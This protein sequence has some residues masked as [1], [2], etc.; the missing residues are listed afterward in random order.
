MG[1]RYRKTSR[2]APEQIESRVLLSAITDLI[3]VNHI[4][5]QRAAVQNLFLQGGSSNVSSPIQNQ[6]ESA[7]AVPSSITV[8]GQTFTQVK[9][10]AT[11]SN[12]GPQG[13]NVALTPTGFLT[14]QELKNETFNAVFKGPYTVGPGPTSD[15][16]ADYYIRGAGQ[17]TT[18]LHGDIQLR[19]VVPKDPGTPFGAVSA[20]FDRNLN[21]NTV[22]GFD[23]ST[24]QL[25][26]NGQQI[27]V[28]AAGRPNFLSP[29]TVDVNS[30]SG[31]YDEAFSQGTI[32]ITYMP[33]RT[34][35]RGL[36][37]Q[38]TAIIRIHALIYT[39]NVDFILANSD[40]DP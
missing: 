19:I 7:T 18:F 11:S 38:G 15:E 6:S 1:K 10:I 29:I 33:S 34:R 25:D 22:L 5:S 30:S 24:P 4:Q 31:L 13:T 32:S 40:I 12:Q 8:G 37:G 26:A 9:S 21:S 3:I 35:T 27:N 36:I 20:I 17:G 28:D 39:P 2:L 23:S 14:P 16:A